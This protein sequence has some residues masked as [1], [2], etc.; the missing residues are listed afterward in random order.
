MLVPHITSALSLA[1]FSLLLSAFF[2]DVVASPVPS[3]HSEQEKRGKMVEISSSSFSWGYSALKKENPPQITDRHLKEKAKIFERRKP[4]EERSEERVNYTS[5]PIETIEV[6]YNDADLDEL[7]IESMDNQSG[8]EELHDEE[9]I[10]PYRRLVDD[11]LDPVYYEKTV[12]PKVE[13][14]KP[15]R[16]NLSMSLYQIL[17]VDERSQSIVVNVWMVQDWYDEFLDWDPHEYDM[18]NKTIIPYKEIWVPDTYLYNSESLEQKRTEALMNAIVQTGYWDEMHRGAAVQLMFPAIYKLSCRMNVRFFPYDQQNCSFIISS[19]THDKSTIDYHPKTKEVN[20][21]NMANNEEWAVISFE[22]ERIEQFFKCCKEPWVMLYA[23]LVIKRKPLYYLI[24]LVVPT[25]IITI[26]AITG[27]F[28]PSSSSSERDEKLY[29]GINT[30]L[31]MSIMMLMVVNQMPSTSNYVPLMGWYYMGI[32]FV[33]VFGT[34]LATF[35]LFIHSRKVHN[36]P[37]S[38]CVRNLIYNRFVS[39]FVLE[40]P[41]TLIELWTEFGLIDQKRLSARNLDP[42]LLAKLEAMAKDNPPPKKV[43][44]SISSHV[45]ATSCYSYEKNLASATQ[46]YTDHI[47]KREHDERRIRTLL[48]PITAVAAGVEH[49]QNTRHIKKQKMRRRCALEWEFLANVID[50]CLLSIFSLVTLFFFVMLC[51][52][53]YFFDV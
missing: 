36:E 14:L 25:S 23:H 5:I 15:T 20:L 50:R 8:Y 52:F 1:F 37:I 10:P 16:V 9:L 45:S 32:I 26:V 40:P 48:E 28:T 30:L 7:L 18:I 46:Q 43:F 19:W 21:K 4:N 31:T 42:V 41:I 49:V 53:D 22:F 39:A 6:D 33:I 17:E 13:Y 12:H 2:D 34:L 51:C 47:K 35:V 29:L 11:L 3:N 44:D 24:N 27:F 38:A